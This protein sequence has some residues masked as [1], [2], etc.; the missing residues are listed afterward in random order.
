MPTVSQAVDQALITDAHHDP[1]TS[2]RSLS[3]VQMSK[4]KLRE[5]RV[6][7][8]AIMPLQEEGRLNSG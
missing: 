1:G 8:Q 3:L 5:V 6:L 7:P 4:L 2:V